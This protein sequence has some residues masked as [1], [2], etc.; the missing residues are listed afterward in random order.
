MSWAPRLRMTRLSP[1]RTSTVFRSFAAIS[2][3]IRSSS[4]TSMGL[5]LDAADDDAELFLPAD[6]P[7]F[8]DFLFNVATLEGLVERGEHLAPAVGDQHVVLDSHAAL[9]GQVNPRL[10]RHDHPRAELF[11]AP[12]LAQRRQLVNVAADAVPEAVAE[13]LAESGPFDHVAGDAIRL[14]RRHA[15]PQEL[16]RRELRVV[17]HLVDLLHLRAD[18]PD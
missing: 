11:F 5:L 7:P 3:T 6:F 8:F 18:A 10:H 1:S 17:D 15:R 13:V 2:L 4:E 14:R 16:D 9:A 12:G